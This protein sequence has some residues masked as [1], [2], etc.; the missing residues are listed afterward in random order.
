VCASGYAG[1]DDKTQCISRRLGDECSRDGEC[2]MGVPFSECAD[3]GGVC[4]CQ[5]GYESEGN[6][7]CTRRVLGSECLKDKDCTGAIDNSLCEGGVC[8]CVTG[9]SH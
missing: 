9:N 7:K 1:T 3:T 4:I 5:D 6:A 2:T 8:V